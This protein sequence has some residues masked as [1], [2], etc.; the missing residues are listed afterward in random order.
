MIKLARIFIPRILFFA[1]EFLL[2]ENYKKFFLLKSD[3]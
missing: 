2:P 1:V 3:Q